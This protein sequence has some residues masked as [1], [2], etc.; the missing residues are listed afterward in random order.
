MRVKKNNLLNDEV[1]TA[2]NNKKNAPMHQLWKKSPNPTASVEAHIDRCNDL[3]ERAVGSSSSKKTDRTR[4]D[5]ALER[6]SRRS[7]QHRSKL[8]HESNKSGEKSAANAFETKSNAIAYTKRVKG[9]REELV[10]DFQENRRRHH[11]EQQESRR[12]H[13]EPQQ[14]IRRQSEKLVV[15]FP[16]KNPRAHHRSPRRTL[17]SSTAPMTKESRKTTLKDS[18]RTAETDVSLVDEAIEE[19]IIKEEENKKKNIQLQ[20]TSEL[21]W[22]QSSIVWGDEECS[23]DEESPQLRRSR[24]PASSRSFMSLMSSD[25]S[26]RSLES[27]RSNP[28]WR[29]FSAMN[30]SRK[31]LEP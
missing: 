12:R 15:D 4:V 28:L 8:K 11:S 10:V 3:P 13:S 24:D 30:V 9:G 2:G 22:S 25:R 23:S 26:F 5:G 29:S 1:M 14:R 19:L 18:D 27:S 6:S 17:A 21:D 31:Q 7:A 20:V 16:T